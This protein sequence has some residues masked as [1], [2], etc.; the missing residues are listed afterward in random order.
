MKRLLIALCVLAPLTVCG[1]AKIVDDL[2]VYDSDV[3]EGLIV[4]EQGYLRWQDGP[5]WQRSECAICGKT[6]WEKAA[7][8]VME[9]ASVF[10]ID[11]DTTI[12]VDI[13]ALGRVEAETMT[14]T[15]SYQVCPR[16][17]AKYGETFKKACRSVVHGFI[18]EARGSET[19]RRQQEHA[20]RLKEIDEQMERLKAERERL[21][22]EGVKL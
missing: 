14:Y 19:D 15:A 3:V 17:N 5:E 12:C 20:K 8:I 10:A 11:A 1:D 18:A 6:I 16:C 9:G 13:V 4:D 7:S 21:V 22:G 2:T